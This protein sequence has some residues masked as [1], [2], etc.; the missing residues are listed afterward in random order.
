MC[1]WLV[2]SFHLAKLIDNIPTCNF[3]LACGE[4]TYF[5]YQHYLQILGC[6]FALF[7]PS[8]R[9]AVRGGRQFKPE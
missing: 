9:R 5:Y 4:F 3:N 7:Q 2:K 1:V 8:D 6:I